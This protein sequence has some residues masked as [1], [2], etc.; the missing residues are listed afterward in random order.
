MRRAR[1][2]RSR[3]A[4][5]PRHGAAALALALILALVLGAATAAIAAP[6]PVRTDAGAELA[7]VTVRGTRDPVEKSYRKMLRGMELFERWHHLAPQAALRYKLLP[8]Q[9][10]TDMDGIVLKVIGDSITLVVPVGA[11]HTFALERNQ[12]AIDEDASVIPNRK[13]RSMTWRTDIRTPGLPANT[14]RL[15]DLRL[16][17]KVGV[18]AGLL[19][20]GMPVLAQIGALVKAFSDVCRG[21]VDQY[22]LFADR[23]LFGVTL[24]AGPRRHVL[25]VNDLYMDMLNDPTS[26]VQLAYLDSQA[27]L[28]R[29]YF[30]ALGDSSWPDDTLV[31]FDYMDEGPL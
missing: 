15:G 24:V 10:G 2:N 20:E 23:A 29:T 9:S 14:R 7:A 31:V 1:L 21:N 17:C 27:L 4:V 13:A 18:E 28:D 26:P 5:A 22:L 30:I 8:R 12:Q 19:S 11:D 16:E 25:S 3:L 6:E